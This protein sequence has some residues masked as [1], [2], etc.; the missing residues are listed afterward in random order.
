MSTAPPAADS[1]GDDARAIPPDVPPGRRFEP[2]LRSMTRI[3]LHPIASPM[4]LG[5]FTIAIASVMTGCLQLGLFDEA[6]R[7]AVAFTVL[8]AFVLQLL[9]SILAFGA[10]DVIAATLMAVFAGSWLPYSLIMLSGAAD[11]LQVLGV[12]NLALLCFGA[13]MTAVTRPKRALWL[14]LAVSLPR[15][16]AT[17]LAGVT[18]A[19]WLTRT[20]GALGLL[21][22]AVAA[23]TA[24]ALMLEDMRSEQVLPI[25]RSGPAH[26]AV[27]GDLSVQLRN[28]ERQAGVRR[29]L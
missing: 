21:V 10:R 12:F 22:A 3:N 7:P 26:L 5:F 13:L 9:V 28:L 29:T 17:G 6:A 19:E 25:G 24:F 1:G 27:E 2:D 11:G 16:A 8:P 4:P 14:V 23:Y 20:S 15:W 18:G